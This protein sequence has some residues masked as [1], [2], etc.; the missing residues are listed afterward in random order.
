FFSASRSRP[1]LHC[2]G[3]GQETLPVGLALPDGNGQ[4]RRSVAARHRPR[5]TLEL[6][7]AR[8]PLLEFTRRVRFGQVHAATALAALSPQTCPNVPESREEHLSEEHDEGECE[9]L[10][11]DS[12]IERK[13]LQRMLL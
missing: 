10:G 12:P 9:L 4:L 2:Q 5:R 7:S 6:W 11:L 3:R 8:S 1:R 13:Q